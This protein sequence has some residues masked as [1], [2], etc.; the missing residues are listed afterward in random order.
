[1]SASRARHGERPAASFAGSQAKATPM[2][3]EDGSFQFSGTEIAPSQRLTA[4]AQLTRVILRS[5]AKGALPRGKPTTRG[6]P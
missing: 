4:L 3:S 6:D 2:R 5:Y 1:M